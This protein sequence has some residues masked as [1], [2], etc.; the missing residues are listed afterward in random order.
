MRYFKLRLAGDIKYYV[1]CCNNQI[2]KGVELKTTLLLVSGPALLIKFNVES[3][4]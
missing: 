4:F 1:K 2:N 3:S